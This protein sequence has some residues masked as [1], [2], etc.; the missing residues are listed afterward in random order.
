MSNLKGS[1][2]KR[3]CKDAFHR[4]EA[5]KTP[6][7]GKNDNYTHSNELAKKREMYLRDVSQYFQS[8]N[9][10]IKLNKLFTKENLDKFFD[11]RLENLAVKTQENYLRGFSSMIQGLQ[12]KNVDIPIL[13][14]DKAY[15]DDRVTILKDQVDI[16]IE[17]R[18]ID[19]VDNVIQNLYE[20]RYTSG[21]VAEIQN[22]LLLRQSEAFHLLQFSEKYIDLNGLKVKGIIGKGNNPYSDKEISPELA[23]KLLENQDRNISKTQYWNDLNKFDISS[24][25]FRFTAARNKYEDLKRSL[26]EKEAKLAISK[27]L[28]H[29][30]IS[31]TDYY[32]ARSLN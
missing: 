21:L 27:E 31:I 3:Q 30:R 14:E 6:R 22:N 23:F 12:Q 9:S 19:N 15:F 25:D 2:F 20:D 5:F 10:E 17:N 28:N 18:Y 16:V 1:D 7:L 32:L 11:Y 29:H 13:K 26:S 4:L 8:Q 24:H